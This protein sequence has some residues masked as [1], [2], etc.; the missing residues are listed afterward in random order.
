MRLLLALGIVLV[1][2]LYAF[3]ALPWAAEDGL[4]AFRVARNWAEGLGPYFNAGTEYAGS[5][6]S[7]LWTWLL[8]S[9]LELGFQADRWARLLAL[10]CDLLTVVAA[11]RLIGARVTWFALVFALPLFGAASASGLETPLVTMAL[12]WSAVTPWATGLLGLVRPE[13]ILA[14][15]VLARGKAWLGFAAGVL[16]HLAL[17]GWFYGGLFPTAAVKS[18]V[19]GTHWFAGGFWLA[20]VLPLNLG[21]PVGAMEHV[22]ALQLAALP[23]VTLAAR[24]HWRL[25]AASAAVLVAYWLTGT[26]G[27]WWYGAPW[28]AGLALVACAAPVTLP[29]AFAWCAVAVLLTLQGPA[30]R[31]VGHLWASERPLIEVA[32]RLEH[33]RGT[34]FLEPIGHVGWTARHLRVV[35]EVGLVT[36]WVAERRAGPPGWWTEVVRRERPEWIVARASFFSDPSRAFAGNGVP[37]RSVAELDSVL[38]GYTLVERYGREA[39]ARSLV[40]LGRR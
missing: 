36:P 37:V 30:W 18:L 9:G 7:L 40:L 24:Q 3:A 25:A 13:G 14:G 12:A 4:I 27:F 20:P 15:A 39:G 35:D 6:T 8:A 38:T 32:Q 2:R 26:A 33:E 10:G 23:L 11:W 22:G 5:V 1:A 29:R 16:I 19:Y 28:Y 34:V 17:N 31:A 21:Q